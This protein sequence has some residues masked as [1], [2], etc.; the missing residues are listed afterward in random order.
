MAG[1][2]D[3]P[4]RMS[5]RET[6]VLSLFSHGK[7]ADDVALLLSI[8]RGTVMDHYRRISTRLETCNRAHTVAEAMRRGLITCWAVVIAG[9][10]AAQHYEAVG[11]V[12]V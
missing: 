9:A 4:L 1:S 2:D 12:I 5:K 3:K 10:L 11:W 8:S 7:S 6:E